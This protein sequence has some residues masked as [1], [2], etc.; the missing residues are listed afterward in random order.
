MQS[1]Y[2]D[3][4]L[5]LAGG[6]V[7]IGLLRLIFDRLAEKVPALG[8]RGIR[9]PGVPS[10]LIAGLLAFGLL[11][12]F[13]FVPTYFSFVFDDCR[14]LRAMQ[15]MAPTD[16]LLIVLAAVTAAWLMA[17]FH[18]EIWAYD[19]FGTK[20][21]VSEAGRN[22][23]AIGTKW[24]VA[25]HIPLLPVRSYEV[26]AARQLSWDRTEYSTKPL[27]SIV[28]QHVWATVRR[29]RWI[30]GLVLLVVVA[31]SLFSAMPCLS[32]WEPQS[33]AP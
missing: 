18:A 1:P 31:L 22:R 8:A 13:L 20:L 24:L 10:V 30:Y 4:I 16:I 27:D 29:S 7:V 11:L 15:I 3:L 14:F 25:V 6:F 19:G 21:F 12:S 32:G 26:L 5:V 28:W 33:V 9:F 23:P 17:R 2:L